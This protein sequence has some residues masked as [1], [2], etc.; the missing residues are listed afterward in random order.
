MQQ[1]VK[2]NWLQNAAQNERKNR[3]EKMF[4]RWENMCQYFYVVAEIAK[5]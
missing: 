5:M 3:N 4:W 2:Q 1:F